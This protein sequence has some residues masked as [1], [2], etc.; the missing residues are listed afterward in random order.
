VAA[1]TRFE[2]GL[3]RIIEISINL[4]RD[5]GLSREEIKALKESLEQE[6]EEKSANVMPVRVRVQFHITPL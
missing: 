3:Q 4:R 6:L 2:S 1:S 5:E